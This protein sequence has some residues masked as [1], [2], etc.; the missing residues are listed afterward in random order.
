MPAPKG[1]KYAKKKSK[2]DRILE[3]AEQF[4]DLPIIKPTILAPLVPCLPETIMEHYKKGKED[5]NRPGK[6]TKNFRFYNK[7]QVGR[8]KVVM[9]ALEVITRDLNEMSR[10]SAWRVLERLLPQI[11]GETYKFEGRMQLKG[12]ISIEEL[13]NRAEE[14]IKENGNE[15]NV[16]PFKQKD[17]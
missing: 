12:G 16:T 14:Y 9:K 17:A 5:A 7:I 10:T 8:V 3:V 11:W 15:R 13:H 2:I 4:G 1:N 6:K